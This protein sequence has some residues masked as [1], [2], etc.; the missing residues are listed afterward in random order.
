MIRPQYALFTLAL[1]LSLPSTALAM[2]RTKIEDPLTMARRPRPHLAPLSVGPDSVGTSDEYAGLP[3]TPMVS[4]FTAIEKAIFDAT[5]L[6]SPT[7]AM[8]AP[9]VA[10]FSTTN[11]ASDSSESGSSESDGSA[12]GSTRSYSI[13]SSHDAEYSN[14]SASSFSGASSSTGTTV[15]TGSTPTVQPLRMQHLHVPRQAWDL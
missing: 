12:S 5:D 11:S 6:F 14:S 3:A 15:S 7:Q 4:P 8:P 1:A 2:H 13:G 10:P 9:M